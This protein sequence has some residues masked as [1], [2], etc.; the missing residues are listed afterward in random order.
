MNLNM[1]VAMCSKRGI[2]INNRIPWH[3][4]SDLKRFK[5]LTIGNG[6]NAVI[7][8]NNT[9]NSLPS[10]LVSRDNLILTRQTDI[11]NSIKHVDNI[12]KW[13]TN[14]SLLEVYC[15]NRNYEQVWVIGG[16]EIYEQY[17]KH[18]KLKHIYITNIHGDFECDSVFPPMPKYFSKTWGR[19]GNE[20][21]LFYDLELYSSDSVINAIYNDVYGPLF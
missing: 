13:F 16:S 11:P 5:K 9:Y 10:T 2:G 3:L 12:S 8:G 4:P 19:M 14:S 15:K 20:N 21:N 7:M 6:K 17:L 18:P 1:I